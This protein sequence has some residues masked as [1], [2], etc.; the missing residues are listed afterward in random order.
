MQNLAS[1]VLNDEEAVE[2]LEGHC[3]HGEEV[4]GDERLAVIRPNSISIGPIDMLLHIE[5]HSAHGKRPWPTA[6]GAIRKEPRQYRRPARV[7][8][9]R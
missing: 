2:Q 7:P 5:K 6:P 1:F 8:S 4:E 9:G 3:R